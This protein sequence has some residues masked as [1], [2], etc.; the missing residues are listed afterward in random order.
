LRHAIPRYS[1]GINEPNVSLKYPDIARLRLSTFC[2]EIMGRNGHMQRFCTY[3]VRPTSGAVRLFAG[4][5]AYA[6][7]H[8]HRAQYLS[9]K[10]NIATRKRL[11]ASKLRL[12]LGGVPDIREPCLSNLNGYGAELTTAS[13]TKSKPS[14]EA[15][16]RRF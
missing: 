14:K 12:Q 10:Q 7:R 4:Y 11:Q 3:R 2:L 13:V 6:C 9:Q 5:G 15:K 8:C 16:T 1:N